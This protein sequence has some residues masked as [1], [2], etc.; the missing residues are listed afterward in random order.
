MMLLILRVHAQPFLSKTLQ[1]LI[2][3]RKVVFQS[4]SHQLGIGVDRKLTRLQNDSLETCNIDSEFSEIWKLHFPLYVNNTF[5]KMKNA[6]T[7]RDGLPALQ[8][9]YYV[10]QL[11]KSESIPREKNQEEK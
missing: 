2:T 11:A 1:W 8:P 6:D 7:P 5:S 10:L 4:N 3:R 9:V